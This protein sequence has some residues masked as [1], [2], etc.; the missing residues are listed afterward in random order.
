MIMFCLWI[1]DFADTEGWK[2]AYKYNIAI[3]AEKKDEFNYDVDSKQGMVIS[4][5]EF[6]TK[7]GTKFDG[8][9]DK[10]TYVEEVHEHYTQHTQTYSCGYKGRSTC[11]RTYWTWD[12]VGSEEKYADKITY[13][14]REYNTSQFNISNFSERVDG[15][16]R[17]TGFDRY[18]YNV[19]PLK[20]TASFL[21]D[22]SD[23]TIKD[24]FGNKQVKLETVSIE[25]LRKDSLSYKVIYNVILTIVSLIILIGM[26]IVAW[27]WVW[28]DGRWSL[29]D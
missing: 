16:H 10:F 12:R 6:V 1:K 25:Q 23:G 2:V 14:G 4:R 27:N 3:P 24:A 9:K 15:Y 21:A 11:T 28:A 29:H 26:G 8:Q 19:V 7:N 20:F 13:F 17:H 22:T 18:Y 5:G